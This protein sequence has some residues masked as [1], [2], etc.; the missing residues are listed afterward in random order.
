[1]KKI[2]ALSIGCLVVVLFAR[3]QEATDYGLQ[4]HGSERKEPTAATPAQAQ[5]SPSVPELSQIDEIFKQTSLGQEADERRM[6]LE[7]RQLANRVANDPEIVAAKKSAESASTDLEKRERLRSYYDIY[8]GKMRALASSA[9]MKRA[10]DAV[11]IE[12]LSHINQPRVRHL[13]DGALPTAT[14]TPRKHH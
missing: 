3:A 13:T 6:H 2:Y 12:H 7:W 1:M 11:K 14:P 8:Y 5:P 9:E 10:L 4:S